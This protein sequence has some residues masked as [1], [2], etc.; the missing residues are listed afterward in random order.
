MIAV[1][2][3]STVV[4]PA[5]AGLLC[6]TPLGAA[7]L[8]GRSHLATNTEPGALY[9]EDILPKPIRLTV[10]KDSFIYYQTDL[11]RVLGSMATGTLVQVIAMSDGLYKV[12]GRARHGDVAGWMRIEELVSKDPGLADK[13]KKFY[14]RQKQVDEVIKNKQVALGMTAAEVKQSLGEPT[15][16]SAKITAAGREETLEYSIYKSVPQ[17]VT[18]RDQFGNLVQN[19]IYVK[20][21]TGKLTLSFANGTVS[22]IE[23]TTGNP[24]GAGGVKIVPGPITVF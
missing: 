18:G 1:F 13:L 24:L 12:R 14:E 2:R 8:P 4:L 22:S 7:E 5:M 15:K 11:Q 23:E 10:A 3:F 6:L 21:E 9:V 20:V 17:A 16:K 19:V